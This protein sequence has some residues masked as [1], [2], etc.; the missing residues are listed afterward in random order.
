MM[1]NQNREKI[2]NVL[3]EHGQQVTASRLA[4]CEYVLAPFRHCS[5]EEIKAHLKDNF[6]SVSLAT[7]YNTLNMLVRI[8]VFQEIKIPSSGMVIYDSTLDTHFHFYDTEKNE[9]FDLDESQVSFDLKGIEGY[10]V[11]KINIVLEGVRKK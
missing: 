3:R 7:I 5:I 10:D 2:I 11:K 1:D 4:I 8:G 9:I 6:P